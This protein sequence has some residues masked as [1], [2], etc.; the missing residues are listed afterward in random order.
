MSSDDVEIVRRAYRAWNDGD[1]EAAADLFDPAIEWHTPPNVPEAGTWRGESEVRHGI[2][3]FRESWDELRAE[4]HE[5][6][7]AGD[8]VVAF[9]RFRGRS[10]ATGL[11]LE[12]VSVDSQVWTVRNR[13]VVRV[14]MY[15]G[16][17]ALAALGIERP[18]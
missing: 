4:V 15:P 14:E 13:K 17:E 9:V 6:F 8:K 11:E 1:L 3:E 10:R 12:G 16:D 18:G 7:E 5:V 2:D